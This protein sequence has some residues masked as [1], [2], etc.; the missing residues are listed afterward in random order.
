M[1]PARVPVRIA[2]ARIGNVICRKTAN[3]PEPQMRPTSS[4]EASSWRIAGPR[5]TTMT[6]TDEATMCTQR[7]PPTE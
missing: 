3:G 2:G 1:K 4:N 5:I 6:G 7:M